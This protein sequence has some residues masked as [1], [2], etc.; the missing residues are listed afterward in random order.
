VVDILKPQRSD[1]WLNNDLTPTQRIGE[2]IDDIIDSLNTNVT[3]IENVDD[4]GATTALALAT[5]LKKE[6][7][8]QIAEANNLRLQ[9]EI[10][11]IKK[12]LNDLEIT[13]GY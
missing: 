7:A 4:G 3:N 11:Q 2:L 13:H 10:A 5:A 6:I 12:R 1:A 8:N 9:G